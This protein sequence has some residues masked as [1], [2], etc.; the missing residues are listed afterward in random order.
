MKTPK[1]IV[2]ITLACA[3][4]LGVFAYDRLDRD[5]KFEKERHNKSSYHH[6]GKRDRDHHDD[7]DYE[8]TNAFLEKL[9]ANLIFEGKIEKKPAKGFNGVWKISG[10]D[11]IVDDKTKIFFDEEIVVR[12]EVEVVA[13]RS[14]GKIKALFIEHD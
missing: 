4:P 11:V 10:Y 5:D 13:K 7:D 3:I 1:K 6:G 12:E 2:A 14:N 8:L 9:G